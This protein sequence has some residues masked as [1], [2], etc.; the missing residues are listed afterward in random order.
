MILAHL[1]QST[2]CVAVAAVLVRALGR[3]SARTRY[4]IWLAASLK[5][6]VPFSVFVAAGDLIGRGISALA[7]T[8]TSSTVRWIDRSLAYWSLDTARSPAPG[9]PLAP[10]Q[11][12][13]ALALLLWLGGTVTLLAWRTRQLLSVSRLARRAPRMHDGREAAMLRSILAGAPRAPRLELRH[14]DDRMEPGVIGILRPTLLWPPGLS[15][16]LTDD[17]LRA[18]L[19]HEVSH[20][21]RRDNAGALLQALVEA[22]FWFHPVVWW[23]GARLV[24]ERE[25]ACDQEVVTMVTDKRSYAEGLLKVCGFCLR[26]PAFVAGIGGA[27]LSQRVERIMIGP[28]T[29]PVSLGV[30]LAL[31][32]V[33]AIAAGAPLAAGVLAAPRG[34]ASQ[35]QQAPGT[36][37]GTPQKIYQKEDDIRMPVLIK[38]TKPKYTRAAMEAKIQ[39]R[40]WLKAVI[41]E[42]GKVGDVTVSKSLDTEHGLDA[43]AVRTVKLW[44][45]R[46]ATKDN[47]PVPVQVDIE[48]SFTLK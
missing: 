43:E 36:T 13:L 25:R 45:F 9:W 41:L 12:I 16:R 15:E 32:C 1:W 33:V 48:M 5:F 21:I 38:E 46:P 24:D 10:D 31:A 39:G 20:A 6:L 14:G 27:S 40:V 26:P 42:T 37:A 11:P 19:A 34:A 47:K 4:G 29:V 35:A 22:L 2:L 23:L 7:A 18:V 28:A 44:E 17:E 30:R 8:G 3:A